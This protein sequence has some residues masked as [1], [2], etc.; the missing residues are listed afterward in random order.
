[1]L[2]IVANFLRGSCE[3]QTFRIRTGTGSN[4]T[5]NRPVTRTL[6]L[7]LT[8]TQAVGIE[9]DGRQHRVERKRRTCVCVLYL[10]SSIRFIRTLRLMP[11]SPE[12]MCM[13]R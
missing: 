2:T 13:Y 3:E 9:L 1:M 11:G 12:A 7:T 4:Q 8:L 5:A 6:A 10:R